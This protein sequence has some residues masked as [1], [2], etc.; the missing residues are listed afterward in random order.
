MTKHL[1]IMSKETINQ[2]LSGQKSIE[3]RFSKHHISPFGEVSIG[4]LI[5]MKPPG[6]EVLGQFKALKVF[7]FEGLNPQDVEKIFKDWGKQIGI[8]GD[9]KNDQYF[10]SKLDSKYGTL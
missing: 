5:Y 6:D 10:K 4:D 1:A 9:F 2:I 8:K 7:Y 3:T